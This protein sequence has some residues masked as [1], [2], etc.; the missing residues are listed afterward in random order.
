MKQFKR[1]PR[2]KKKEFV[3]MGYDLSLLHRVRRNREQACYFIK[4]K[5]AIEHFKQ[6]PEEEIEAKKIK[7]Y[8]PIM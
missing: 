8:E 5:L 2:K 4:V 7:G 6:I 3:K 1:L